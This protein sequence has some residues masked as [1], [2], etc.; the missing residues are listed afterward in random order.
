MASKSTD[1]HRRQRAKELANKHEREDRYPHTRYHNRH[2]NL[3]MISEPRCFRC[4]QPFTWRD[5]QNNMQTVTSEGAEVLYHITCPT[6][7]WW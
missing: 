5:K 3:P 6:L 7:R 4:K 1:K 2:Y